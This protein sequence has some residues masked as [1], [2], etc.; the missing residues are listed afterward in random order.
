MRGN[1]QNFNLL[2]STQV[3]TTKLVTS[4]RKLPLIVIALQE[5]KAHNPIILWYDSLQEQKQ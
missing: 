4:R 2:N 1:F 5:G 3:D